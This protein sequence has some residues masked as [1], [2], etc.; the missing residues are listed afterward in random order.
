VFRDERPE[1]G[2]CTRRCLKGQSSEVELTQQQID[3]ARMW[4]RSD[5]SG[6]CIEWPGYEAEM[7]LFEAAERLQADVDG[8]LSG[9]VLALDTAAD[10]FDI[11]TQPDGTFEWFWRHRTTGENDGGEGLPGMPAALWRIVG[12]L[13]RR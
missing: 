7:M 11:E 13:P 8:V 12:R 10:H 2:L 9:D 3:D 5:R 6:G 4:F 1:P